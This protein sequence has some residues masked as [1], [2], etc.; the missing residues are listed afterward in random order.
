MEVLFLADFSVIKPEPGLIIWTTI[1]FAI[2][3]YMMSKFA[4]GPIQQALRKREED[5]QGALDEAKKAR[6]EMANLQAQN[7]TL[8]A[9]AQEERAKIIKDA[10]HAKETILK[11][12]KEKAK[13][14]AQRI[15]TNAKQEIENQKLAAMTELKN[16]IGTI[17][18]DIAGKVIDRELKGDKEQEKFVNEQVGKA[19][20]N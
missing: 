3:W 18:L 10:K 14:E 11:E 5:I 13:E 12:A 2:F 15:V 1:I 6:E 19:K 17:A 16:Q 20:F 8:M 7:E 9:E 4:F